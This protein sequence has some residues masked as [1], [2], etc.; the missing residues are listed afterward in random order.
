M[1]TRIFYLVFMAIC[2]IAISQP[3][4]D[5]VVS[6][7]GGTYFI[8][9][10][11]TQR[12]LEVL[13]ASINPDAKVEL[14][15]FSAKKEQ[16]F[17]IKDAGDGYYFIRTN[18]GGL[19]LTLERKQTLVVTQGSAGVSPPGATY[20][21]KQQ[22]LYS[23]SPADEV[24]AWSKSGSQKWKILPSSD[25]TCV[26]IASKNQIANVI[27]PANN[28][29]ITYR[30]KAISTTQHWILKP[31]SLKENPDVITA[32]QGLITECNY[33]TH[34]G[35]ITDRAI[36]LA[37]T[38]PQWRAVGEV[39]TPAGSNYR[40]LNVCETVEGKVISAEVAFEEN[41]INHYTHDFN[42]NV[43]PDPAFKYI[44]SKN[45][46]N[47]NK[48]IHV[49]WETGM[50]QGDNKAKNIAAVPN[51]K[52]QSCGF[53][54]AGHERQDPIWNWP[55]IND[56]VHV[57][58]QWVW[59]IG[60]ELKAEIHPA[61]FVAIQRYLPEKYIR[62]GSYYF[63]TRCDL[64]ASAD[65]GALINNRGL[66]SFA[67]KMKMSEKNYTV[68]FR[69]LLPQPNPN[70]QLRVGFKNQK[71]NNFPDDIEVVTYGNGTAD[72]PEPN[73]QITLPWF[74]GHISDNAILART[75]FIYWDD[76]IT[77]GVSTTYKNSLRTFQVTLESVRILKNIEEGDLDAGE[78]RMF[79]N[80][81]SNWIFLN[82]Y[83][84]PEDILSDG[85][86]NA[87][88]NATLSLKY[89]RPILFTDEQNSTMK[90]KFLFAFDNSFEIYLPADKNFRCHVNGWE[91]DY[92]D[93]RFGEIMNPYLT[94]EDAK[95][96]IEQNADWWAARQQNTFDDALG[97]AETNIYYNFQSQTIR[98]TSKG[99][100]GDDAGEGKDGIYQV[101]FK[102]KRL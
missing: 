55:S 87:I 7:A 67:Q 9:S 37:R 45:G 56:W 38:I 54:S 85:L 70:A 21:L 46:N 4:V 31:A 18:T 65:G 13:S 91:G 64:F 35:P 73:V 90:E 23:S 88:D 47:I 75:M 29:T 15:N 32:R 24:A 42:F 86:G 2:N 52:G 27:E 5:Q 66:T 1:K 39:N 58:G 28:S 49:E 74:S 89:H 83:C 17:T 6:Y 20:E 100:D 50:A 34:V 92:F 19:Y 71:G 94:C 48:S 82:E 72:I 68:T 41:P 81:G 53:F 30:A 51:R 43:A 79:A 97:V 62:G 98:I 22:N 59:D 84:E 77:N 80:I 44:L 95:A 63:A 78:A 36:N 16:K 26:L 96:Y 10:R 61:R 102:L 101:Q 12:H 93:G 25:P 33:R 8:K 76:A 11:S 14:R 99:A 40:P 57:E 60:H 69:H 3:P